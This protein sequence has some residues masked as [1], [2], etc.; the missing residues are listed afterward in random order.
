MQDW[1]WAGAAELG[2]GIARGDIDPVDLAAVY[3]DAI[4]AHPA[5]P[6]IYA[7]TTPD[8]AMFEAKAASERAKK[9]QRLSE[10]DGVPVC[11]K[12]LFDTS[13]TATEAGTA[14][15]KGR[16]PSKDAHVLQTATSMGLVCLGKTHMSEIAFS[17][18][19][20]N[21]I[22][23]TSPNVNDSDAVP[24]GSSSGAA[25][26]VAFGL[27]P[28]AIGSDTGGSVRIPAAWNDLVGLKTTHGRLS[29][30]GVVPLCKT[31]DTVGPLCRNVEDAA[32]SLAAL[33]GIR[34]IDLGG[35]DLEGMRFLIPETLVLDDVQEGP[36]KG[37]DWAV[38]KLE[39]AGAIIERRA[40]PVIEDAL[41][42]GGPLFTAD[43]YSAWRDLVE[44]HPEKM[45]PPI[46]E[47]VRAGKEVAAHDYL[48]TWRYL[49]DLRAQYLSATRGYNAVI[50]PT[51]PILPPNVKRLME[52]AEYYVHSN[53][54][55]LRN[56]RVGNLFGLCGLSLP[57]NVPSSGILFNSAPGTEERL[58]R[59]GAAVERA[60]A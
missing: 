29:L 57:T 6:Q 38:Q 53:L 18:L 17:G 12:D 16:V 37:F 59:I 49:H 8:R 47:R 34:A 27:A 25:A 22:T 42:I 35:V 2:R 54:M 45:Y 21:P 4:H 40:V 43:A 32:A 24:G 56:T 23:A 26:S 58:L 11:W 50:F 19:G 46:L 52:D 36:Q 55:A 7:R 31:F 13:G 51:A 44:S 1:L 20:L 5:G 15:L 10:L 3:L 33:E 30:K 41:A 60:L 48:T 28:L 14:L 39:A 9:G